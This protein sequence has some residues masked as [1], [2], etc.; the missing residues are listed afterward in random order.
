MD[1]LLSDLCAGKAKWGSGVWLRGQEEAR[2]TV[3]PNQGFLLDEY[4]ALPCFSSV[5]DLSIVLLLI[6]PLTGWDIG[7]PT[8]G[9]LRAI[10]MSSVIHIKATVIKLWSWLRS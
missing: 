9:S 7:S 10:K 1:G 6:S 2:E 8:P 4:P 3:Y 5:L